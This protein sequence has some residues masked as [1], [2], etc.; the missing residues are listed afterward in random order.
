MSEE[1]NK[2]IVEQITRF[3]NGGYKEVKEALTEKMMEAAE[4]LQFE[5]AKEYRD[6]IAYIEALMEKQK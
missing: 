6:Q 1:E 2:Q 5:R 4:Q 3:L